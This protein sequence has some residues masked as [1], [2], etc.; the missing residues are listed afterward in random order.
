MLTQFRAD[1][2]TAEAR[3]QSRE[4]TWELDKVQLAAIRKE[5]IATCVQES[6]TG[7]SKL[8]HWPDFGRIE[9]YGTWY[10]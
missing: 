4:K 10:G 5:E 2:Q 8:S 3:L 7:T 6:A 1:I 9:R